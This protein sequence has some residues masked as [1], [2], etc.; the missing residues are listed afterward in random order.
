MKNI[1][2]YLFVFLINTFLFQVAFAEPVCSVS[3]GKKTLIKEALC[4]K[5]SEESV[6]KQAGEKC[7]ELVLRKRAADTAAQIN[8]LNKCGYSDIAG[9]LY[10]VSLRV[11][12]YTAPLARCIGYKF[13]PSE[14]LSKA[15]KEF[16]QRAIGQTCTPK[17]RSMLLN[18]MNF[19]NDSIRKSEVE[20][21][22]V[23][24]FSKLNIYVDENGNVFEKT[25]K[26]EGIGN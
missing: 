19:F 22:P 3:E 16:D 26:T 2:V 17:L 23:V 14:L 1:I 10:E 21:G 4:G 18:R 25:F 20:P 7:A 13:D 5:F 12:A 8:A 11:I 15:Q 6:Y 9:R 24:F